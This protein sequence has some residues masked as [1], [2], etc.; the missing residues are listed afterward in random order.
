[1]R[2]LAAASLFVAID[3]AR[4]AEIV[5]ERSGVEKLVAQALFK[6]QGRLTLTR[7]PCA[8]HLEQPAVSLS[9]GRIQI[10]AHL[11]ARVG[12]VVRGDCAGVELASWTK[13]SGRPA[14]AGGSVRLEDIR[15]DEVDDATTRA[16]LVDSGL[17]AALPNAVELDV[18]GALQ[19]MLQQ[20]VEKMQATVESFDFQEVAVAND[21]LSLRFNFRLVG[22]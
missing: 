7:G 19:T 10:R 4:S 5:L 16:L 15:I 6:D 20:S 2:F 9:N 18:R 8:S 17:A 21:R 3:D 11:S 14:P 13:V 12:F 22:K 1:M